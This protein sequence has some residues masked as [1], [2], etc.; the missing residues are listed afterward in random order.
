MAT[1]TL[2]TG[3]IKLFVALKRMDKSQ[4]VWLLELQP[5]KSRLSEFACELTKKAHK[6]VLTDIN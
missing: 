6:N 4:A 2:E 3:L 5:T 1:R